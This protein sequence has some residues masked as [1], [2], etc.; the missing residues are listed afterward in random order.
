[1]FLQWRDGEEDIYHPTPRSGTCSSG[2][3]MRKKIFASRPP[4][5]HM[6]LWRRDEEEDIYLPTPGAAHAPP[7]AR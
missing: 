7:A 6:L 4:E 3:A 5:R 2:G 1:M